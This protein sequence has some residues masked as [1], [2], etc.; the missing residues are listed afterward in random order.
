LGGAHRHES[1]IAGLVP[2]ISGGTAPLLMAGTWPG[3]DEWVVLA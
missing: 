2:A 1:I 3:H